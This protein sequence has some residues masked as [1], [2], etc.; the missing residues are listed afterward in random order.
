[1][2]A[3]DYYNKYA[4]KIFEE[5]VEEEVEEEFREEFLSYLKKATRFWIWAAAP[6]GTVWIFTSADMT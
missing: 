6:A 2:D 3:I 4:A 1:M 5:T